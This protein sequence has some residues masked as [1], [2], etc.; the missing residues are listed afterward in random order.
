MGLFAKVLAKL[1]VT[2]PLGKAIYRCTECRYE[3]F[4]HETS[5][6]KNCRFCGDYDYHREIARL[7]GYR[8]A[9]NFAGKAVIC[10]KCSNAYS[11]D[12]NTRQCPECRKG[13]LVF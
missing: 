2:P 9:T 12:I 3:V 1:F 4:W 8:E 7:A 10:D 5:H 11:L 13:K 6:K